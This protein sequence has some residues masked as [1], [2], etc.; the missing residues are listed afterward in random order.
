MSTTKVTRH[1]QGTQRM[2]KILLE[3]VGKFNAKGK[4][5]KLSEGYYKTWKVMAKRLEDAGKL[6]IR[7]GRLY[8]KTKSAIAVTSRAAQTT[9]AVTETPVTTAQPT[10]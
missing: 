2:E 9:P 10:A 3:R 4:G 7:H 8:I 6:E 1:S 5:F